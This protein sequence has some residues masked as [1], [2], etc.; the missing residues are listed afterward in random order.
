LFFLQKTTKNEVLQIVS[1]GEI[2][3]DTI[4]SSDLKQILKKG[5]GQMSRLILASSSPRRKELLELANLPFE[6]LVSDIEETIPENELP[7][8]IV[9]L[10]ARQK[11]MAVAEKARDAYVIGADTV[12]VYNDIILGKPKTTEDA[13]ATLKMLS[14]KTHE[15]LTGVSIISPESEMTFFERTKV[16]FWP[17]AEEEIK[18]YIVSGEPM[19]KAGSYGIQGRGSLLVKKIEGDYFSVVGLP[20]ARTVRELKKLGFSIN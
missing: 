11:A 15:V 19:D 1:D 5:D 20:I 4:V 10:L 17:L 12:V 2:W 13:Y 18:Q 14:D 7:E 6:I 8:T 9:Q 3:Y 16:T